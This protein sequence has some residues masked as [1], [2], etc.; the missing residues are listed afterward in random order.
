MNV[1]V[2]ARTLEKAGL[3][4]VLVTNMPFWAGKTGVPRTL[5]V[6]F[7]FGHLLGQPNK[8]DQQIRVIMQALN[9]LETA[10]NPGE[11]IHS[12][13]EWPVPPEIAMKDWQPDVPSPVITHMSGKIRELMRK[14]K[15][16][17]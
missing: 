16:L 5:A 13:E 3:S 11:I 1:P 4:T 14:S 10:N 17:I 9:V 12:D 2:L 15:K 7:P 6:E 8:K